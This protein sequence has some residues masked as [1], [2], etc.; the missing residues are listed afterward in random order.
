MSAVSSLPAIGSE[1][2]FPVTAPMVMPKCLCPKHTV[3]FC[4]WS[5]TLI[6]GASLAMRDE[7]PS[8]PI[9]HG[10]QARE[11]DHRNDMPE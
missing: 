2:S 7:S 10:H 1:T 11:G 6:Q 8:R 3:H 4:Y 5:K 9:A